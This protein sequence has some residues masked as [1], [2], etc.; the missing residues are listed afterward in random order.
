MTIDLDS[1]NTR[2]FTQDNWEYFRLRTSEE[3]SKMNEEERDIFQ[4]HECKHPTTQ[5]CY[6]ITQSDQTRYRVQCVECGETRPIAKSKLKRPDLAIP[7]K[8]FDVSP[9]EYRR[10]KAE[11]E[12]K[13]N[14]LKWLN[15]LM[16]RANKRQIQYENYLQ[17]PQWKIKRAK[18]L[19][20]ANGTCE[21]CGENKA[22]EVHHLTYDRIY[23]EMLFDLV[24]VCKSCH[25]QLHP[26]KEQS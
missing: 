24:A 6:Q 16:T 13:K 21:G 1:I 14:L 23:N 2:T 25:D 19:K 15:I 18:V 12:L 9:W 26:W 20:R 10:Q 17:S 8:K 5:I 11:P 4:R 22:V 7:L 3:I